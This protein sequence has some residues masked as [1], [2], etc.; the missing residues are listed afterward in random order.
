MIRGREDCYQNVELLC[1]AVL[2]DNFMPG[3][4]I[5]MLT[6]KSF[7]RKTRT[8]IPKPLRDENVV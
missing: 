7:V 8:Y 6:P 3:I 5:K 4:T 1:W 2:Y